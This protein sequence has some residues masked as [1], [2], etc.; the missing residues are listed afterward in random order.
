[1]WHINPYF[2]DY[3]KIHNKNLQDLEKTDPDYTSADL[4]KI[5]YNFK[6]QDLA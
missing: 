3:N 4:E 5:L 6:I 1:M 2:T